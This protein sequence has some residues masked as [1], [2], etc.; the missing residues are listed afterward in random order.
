MKNFWPTPQAMASAP[1][2][3]KFMNE[4]VKV[5]VSHTPFEPGW[6][7]V[8]VI[9]GDVAGGIK[10]LKE[11]PGKN[12]IIFGSNTLCISLLQA[13]LLDEVQ[14][15]VNP[16]VLGEGTPLFKGLPKKVELRLKDTHPFKSGALLLTY[17]PEY[18]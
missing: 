10:K 8:V 1:D 15:M 16:V 7:N 9:S 6:Q 12:I 2:I 17:E 11:Q 3:A 14:L 5:V 18:R 13:G 4:K